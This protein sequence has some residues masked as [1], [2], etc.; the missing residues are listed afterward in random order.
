MSF[1]CDY[2]FVASKTT[3][4]RTSQKKELSPVGCN[5]I[6]LMTS[7]PTSGQILITKPQ[8]DIIGNRIKHEKTSKVNQI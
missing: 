2:A 7:T 8:F 6:I 1:G 4:E 5:G 3:P